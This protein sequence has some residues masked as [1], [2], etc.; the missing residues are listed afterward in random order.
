M[1][2]IQPVPPRVPKVRSGSKVEYSTPLDQIGKPFGEIVN[3]LTNISLPDLDYFKELK[4][5]GKRISA[6]RGK[7]VTTQKLDGMVNYSSAE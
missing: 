5:L 1:G 7:V 4:N 6:F 3:E 2:Q